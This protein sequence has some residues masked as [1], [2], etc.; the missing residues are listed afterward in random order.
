MAAVLAV[1]REEPR[2]EG[3]A[4]VVVEL[5]QSSGVRRRSLQGDALKRV[6]ALLRRVAARFTASARG[7]LAQE[8]LEQIGA[9]EALKVFDRYD[10]ARRGSQCVEDLV[11]RA[12]M[13]ACVEHIQRHAHDVHVSDWG[14]RG[15]QS[16]D[17]VHSIGK[18]SPASIKVHSYDS[19]AED[20]TQVGAAARYRS[21]EALSP[22]KMLENAQTSTQLRRALGKL[23]K[24]QRELVLRFYGVGQREESLRSIAALTD[25]SRAKLAAELECALAALRLLMTD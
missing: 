2:A 9:I 7:S 17:G 20:E 25:R 15:R 24:E 11:N 23:T 21:E 3:L 22:E 1:V 18:R 13:R 4:A 10:H 5:Q 14:T 19:P 6:R 12:A 16:I 8:D